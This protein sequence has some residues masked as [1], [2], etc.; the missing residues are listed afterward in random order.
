M[1]QEQKDELDHQLYAA[2][3]AWYMAHVDQYS[4]E[5]GIS[6]Y[7]DGDFPILDIDF[8]SAKTKFTIKMQIDGREP[9]RH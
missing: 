2:A 5:N 8:H 6:G 1:T 7:R 4:E 9:V 3:A